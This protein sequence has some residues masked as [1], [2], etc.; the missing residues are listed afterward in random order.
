MLNT[1][2]AAGLQELP[3]T[4]KHATRE[5]ET[6]IRRRRA[7]EEFEL[8]VR[9]LERANCDLEDFAQTVSHD[10]KAPLWTIQALSMLLIENYAPSLDETGRGYLDEVRKATERM[11]E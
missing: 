6:I 7:E 8:Y 1:K 10:L 11:N 5:W 4:A 3:W 9:E 2:S